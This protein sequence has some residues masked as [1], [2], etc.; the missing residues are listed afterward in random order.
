MGKQSPRF[1]LIFESLQKFL[2]NDTLAKIS[3]PRRRP[4]QDVEKGQIEKAAE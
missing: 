1:S 2:Q 4:I 3:C